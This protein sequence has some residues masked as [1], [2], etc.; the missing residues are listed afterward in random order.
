[1]K[2]VR[3]ID[4]FQY[5]DE[6]TDKLNERISIT[7]MRVINTT[8]DEGWSYSRRRVQFLDKDE[9]VISEADFWQDEL[10]DIT[11]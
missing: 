4:V 11:E 5:E 1:M 6:E 7:K 3:T 2:T 10:K 9:N 8:D